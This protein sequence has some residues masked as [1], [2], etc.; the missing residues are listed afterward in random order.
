M[1]ALSSGADIENSSIPAR[2]P[3][4]L[5]ASLDGIQKRFGERHLSP[6][7]YLGSR[8]SVSD[9]G[10]KGL[11]LVRGVT[12]SAPLVRSKVQIVEGKWP[13]PGEIPSRKARALKVGLQRGVAS[14]RQDGYV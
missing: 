5:S 14:N 6:E 9:D 1:Y 13:G 3:A 8:I 4:L 2:T 10:V 12:T 11:G 7:L